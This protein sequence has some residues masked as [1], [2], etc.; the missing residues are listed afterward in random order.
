MVEKGNEESSGMTDSFNQLT[1]HL[2]LRH[3]DYFMKWLELLTLEQ[4]YLETFRTE[5][6]TMTSDERESLGR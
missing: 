3:L 1:H 4:S 2:D 5:I 6:W